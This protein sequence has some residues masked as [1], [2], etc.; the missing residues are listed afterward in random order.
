MSRQIPISKV[1]DATLDGFKEAQRSYEKWSGGY[2]LWQA[3]EYLISSSVAK[4]IAGL[5]GAKYIT[6][7][8]G[9]TSTLEDAGA[10]GKG[11]LPGNIREK[12]KVDILFWWGDGS[13]RA[14]IE[15]KNQI[16]SKDQYE[17]DIKRIGA[18]LSK[19]KEQSSL[20]FGIFAFYESAEDG[21]IKSSR[22]KVTDRVNKIYKNCREILDGGYEVSLKMTDIH[23][24][25]DSSWVAACLLIK[26]K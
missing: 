11:R 14:V 24:I 16:Y 19:N 13:P 22:E 25:D 1:V 23:T 21:P 15:I 7:E 5:E 9:A 10:K 17:K 2:W 3:P 4:S 8:H 18:F 26:T 12:G 6:L 20:Q